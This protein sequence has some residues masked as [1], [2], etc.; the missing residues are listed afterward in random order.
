MCATPLG[1]RSTLR[2][3][4]GLVLAA[5]LPKVR[6]SDRHDEDDGEGDG[7]GG[8]L[9]GIGRTDASS[10][11]S[12]L[13]IGDH[14]A[15][16]AREVLSIDPSSSR[17]VSAKPSFTSS[18]LREIVFRL[19]AS[20]LFDCLVARVSE[21]GDGDTRLDSSVAPCLASLPQIG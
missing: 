18:P 7:D 1:V 17:C 14:V 9:G 8:E 10:S 21:E 15:S 11:A 2:R 16:K 4:V 19:A 6:G 12:I 13:L 3:V 5:I 20:G